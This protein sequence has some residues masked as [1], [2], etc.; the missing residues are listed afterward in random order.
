MFSV[1]LLLAILPVLAVS[2]WCGRR[3]MG[4]TAFSLGGRKAG[5]GLVAGIISGS[6]IGGGATIGT[7]QMAYQ[8]GLVAW[9]F[10]L[11]VGLGLLLL[12]RFFARPLRESGLETVPQYLV[13]CYGPA[14]GPI[15]SLLS[16]LGIFFACSSS[17]LP[18]IGM[19]AAI[20]N[21][22]PT[23]AGLLLLIL[24]LV[25][26]LIGGQKGAGISGIIK[27]ALLWS[28]LLLAALYAAH[29]LFFGT[30]TPADLPDHAWNLFASRGWFY[31]LSAV[32]ATAMGMMTAQMYIQALYSARDARAAERGAYLGA[33]IAIPVGL[34][35]TLIGLYARA[36][37][38]ELA[39]TP[40][41]ALPC[42][43]M[44]DLPAWLGGLT[45]GT[46]ILTLISS[47]AAQ[48]LAIGTML[49]RDLGGA[50]LHLRSEKWLLAL[51]RLGILLA[52]GAVT[53]Y[54][55]AHLGA[56]VLTWNYLSMSLRGGGILLPLLLAV[57]TRGRIADY[58]PRAWVLAAMLLPTALTLLSALL[59]DTPPAAL[60]ILLSAVLLA[61]G[62]L[63]RRLGRQLSMKRQRGDL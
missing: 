57:L 16:C 4:A 35:S 32:A 49:S 1:F 15:V 60:P 34:M 12:G 54:C 42:V 7:A 33:A 52:L 3:G 37:H 48:A 44:Q 23:A 21:I 10:T 6:S 38:P 30:A 55:L 24:P 53:A 19:T 43:L 47:A 36:R 17:V 29:G 31:P 28:A 2:V 56:S 18:G 51:N 59:S 40:L 63:C 26:I 5:A 22:S 41:L 11:G 61:A 13:Q 46:I 50:L 62:A 25:Y 39:A 14:A 20:F 27:A 9:C 45:L 58:I 8:Y